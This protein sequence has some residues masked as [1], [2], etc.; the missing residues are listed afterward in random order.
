MCSSIQQSKDTSKVPSQKKHSLDRV[1][2]LWE[3]IARFAAI[4]KKKAMS[5][6]SADEEIMSW[7]NDSP[8][9]CPQGHP[10]TPNN[11]NNN[12]YQLFQMDPHHG[13]LCELKFHRPKLL[14]NLATKI[15]K[16]MKQV[17]RHF[18]QQLQFIQLPA[19]CTYCFDAIGLASGRASS[20]SLRDSASTLSVE[21]W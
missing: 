2:K 4:I 10:A 15:L 8:N 6:P 11:N 16:Q 1:R 21:I 18:L 9:W 20:L 14:H 13:T 12:K 3:I 5:L 7:V 19:H 17:T